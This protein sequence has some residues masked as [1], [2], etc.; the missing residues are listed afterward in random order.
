MQKIKKDIEKEI[1]EYELDEDESLY[2][3][4][5]EDAEYTYIFAK[6]VPCVYQQ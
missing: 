4:P 1:M 6:N 2:K 5:V 3:I